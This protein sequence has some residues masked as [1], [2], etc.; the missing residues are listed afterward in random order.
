MQKTIGERIE[1]FC[2]IA[3]AVSGVLLM[4]LLSGYSLIYTAVF[5]SNHDNIPQLT[6]GFT[7]LAIGAVLVL[8]YW[9]GKWILKDEAHRTRNIGFCSLGSVYAFVYGLA[10]AFF[11]KYYVSWDQKLVSFFAEQFALGID[12]ISASDLDYIGAYPH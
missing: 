11:C 1:E 4:L 8:I 6:G 9:L 5:P 10:W 2:G 7:V 3:L 12:D